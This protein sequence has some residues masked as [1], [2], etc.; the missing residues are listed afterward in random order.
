M[1]R[2]HIH[3]AVL[4]ALEK[5]G[6][7]ITNDPFK[8]RTG[9]ISIEIDVAAERI[10]L[11]ERGKEQI[12]VE[13]KTFGNPSLIYSFHAAVGQYLDYKS[14]LRDAGINRNLYLAVSEAAYKK[15]TK[16]E[17]FRL[18]LAEFEIKHFAVNLETQTIS[19]WI[20]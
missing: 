20:E 16:V 13:I 7:I 18:R 5:A 8:L 17:F 2:D 6:W 1:A 15:L 3:E 11:A 14:A 19:Q 9:G 12:F 4:L 10:L